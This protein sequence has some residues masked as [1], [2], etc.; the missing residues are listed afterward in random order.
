ML[1]KVLI[2]G[3]HS[4]FLEFLNMLKGTTYWFVLRI[5]CYFNIFFPRI[6]NIRKPRA[7]EKEWNTPCPNQKPMA[8]HTQSKE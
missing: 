6:L 3:V 5:I 2:I 1:F 7:K 4:C 8:N